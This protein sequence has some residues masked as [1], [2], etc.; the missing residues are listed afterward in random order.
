MSKHNFFDSD[1]RDKYLDDTAQAVGDACGTEGGCCGI[2]IF[3]V[4][5]LCASIML[6]FRSKH[7]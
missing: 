2:I 5:A 4:M 7:E 1:W 3:A 6:L